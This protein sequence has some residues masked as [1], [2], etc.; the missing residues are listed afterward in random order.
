MPVWEAN[1]QGIL[2]QNIWTALAAEGLGASLQHTLQVTPGA[3]EALRSV[4]DVPAEWK[5]SCRAAEEQWVRRC[6][7]WD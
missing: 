4:L 2:Q 1:A 5:V 3:E 6:W 7:K